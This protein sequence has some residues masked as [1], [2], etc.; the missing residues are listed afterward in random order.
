MSALAFELPEQSGTERPRD[1][2]RMLV[3]ERGRPLVHT[4]FLDL[5]THLR[6]GDLLIVNAS[7]TLPAALPARRANGEPVDLHLSTPVPHDETR[8]AV[9]VRAR[10]HRVA[11]RN[12]TLTLPGG[13]TAVLEEPYLSPLWVAALDL[14]EPVLAYLQRHGAPIRYAHDQRERPLSDYQTIFATEPG[15]AEMPSAGRPFTRRV[16]ERLRANGID[17]QR[18]TLHTGVSSQETHE[19]PY[20][21]RYAVPRHTAKRINERSGRVIAVGTTVVRTLETVA[22]EHGVVHAGTGWTNLMVTPETSPKVVDGLL[23]GWHEPEASHLLML[24]AIAGATLL[25]RSYAAAVEQGY[26]W[27]EFGDVHL[28]LT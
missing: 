1:E 22:D 28:I 16:L 8:W 2:V 24:E 13:A 14:P 6:A 17:V 9:E 3:A 27:H 19:R 7:A 5:P 15:S 11:A 23:T 18:I 4:T 25:R 12:E 10:G 21:E 26:R 20:P